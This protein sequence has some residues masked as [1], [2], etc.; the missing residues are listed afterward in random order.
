V[1]RNANKTWQFGPASATL[2]VAYLLVLQGLAVGFTVG[3]KSGLFAGSICLSK[4]S[5]S[6][7]ADPAAPGRQSHNSA[8]VCCVLHCSGM[9]DA[10]AAAFTAQTPPLR[11]VAERLT[12]FSAQDGLARTATPPLGSRAPPSSIS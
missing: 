1:K 12:P 3:A 6:S 9:G 8:D 7:K 4:G 10:T 11:L 5:G 2:L